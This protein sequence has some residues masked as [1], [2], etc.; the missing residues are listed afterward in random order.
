[1]NDL[2]SLRYIAVEGPI[3]V[4][5][6]SL[7]RRLANALNAEL[8]LEL[9]EGNPFLERFYQN[10]AQHALATQ[11]F[12]LT[13]RMEQLRRLV[14][15]ARQGVQVTD[16]LME[17]DDLF[18][19]LTLNTEEY[20]LYR[21][22]RDSIPQVLPQPDLVIYLQ[23]PV[24]TL[25]QRIGQ[26]GHA[27]ERSIDP[28]YLKRLS[29]TYASFFYHYADA[30]LLI[31]NASEINWVERDE[32]FQQLLDFIPAARAGRHYFNPLPSRD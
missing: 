1:M 26:R 16:F 25:R 31:V 27:H 20:A 15:D 17:K 23:A 4:G 32:D 11:L 22:I 5:K 28:S 7:S 6:T 3:G 14:G 21:R 30:P 19:K 10:P 18:A 8:L 29:D 12:F 2:S 9:P 13:Q 24:D